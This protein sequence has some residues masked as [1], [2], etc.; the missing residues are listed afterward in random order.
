MVNAQGEEQSALRLIV[1][2]GGSREGIPEKVTSKSGIGQERGR[3]DCVCKGP[4]AE[5]V[6][7]L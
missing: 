7:M 4:G 2:V 3:G 6:Q 5:R 1:M